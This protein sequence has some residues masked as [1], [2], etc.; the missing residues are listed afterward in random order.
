MVVVAVVVSCHVA[1]AAVVLW[2]WSRI[3]GV[4]AA[5]VV[6]VATRWVAWAAETR[7]VR[8]VAW[9]AAIRTVRWCVR[10]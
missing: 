8:W 4:V 5:V 10:L 7:T 2:Q 9:A 6:V 3:W 1:M